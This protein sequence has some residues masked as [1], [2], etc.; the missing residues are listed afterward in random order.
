[1]NIIKPP[2]ISNISTMSSNEDDTIYYI[3]DNMGTLNRV[4]VLSQNHLG[5]VN[6]KT[7]DEF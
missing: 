7:L 5:I 2:F 6:H 4:S 1:M 3:D